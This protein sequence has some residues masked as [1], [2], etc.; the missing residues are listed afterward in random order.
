KRLFLDCFRIDP[1]DELTQRPLQAPDTRSEQM[2]T[3]VPLGDGAYRVESSAPADGE[4]SRAPAIARALVRLVQLEEMDETTVR[5]PCGR[6]HHELMGL[7]LV[8][9]QNLRAA[10]RE[11]ELT[12]GRGVLAAPSAQQ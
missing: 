9:A 7:M 2:I 5:F 11:E 12:A 10:L 8:R 3:L 4:E 1:D 6:D